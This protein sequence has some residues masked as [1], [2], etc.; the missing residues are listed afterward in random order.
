MITSTTQDKMEFHYGG[1]M[2]YPATDYI[3][4]RIEVLTMVL[5]ELYKIPIKTE[6]DAIQTTRDIDRT[7]ARLESFQEMQGF[8]EK[9]EEEVWSKHLQ[10]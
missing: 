6:K 7:R 4:N 5:V 3:N 8:L 10:D 1:Q 2:N 9:Q